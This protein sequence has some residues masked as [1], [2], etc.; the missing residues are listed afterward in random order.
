MI[1][2]IIIANNQQPISPENTGRYI[3]S[4]MIEHSRLGS[5][6]PNITN[7]MICAVVVN[8]SAAAEKLP[9]KKGD[10]VRLCLLNPY[11]TS[12]SHCFAIDNI[13]TTSGI[14]AQI[15][16]SDADVSPRI[17]FI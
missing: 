3:S 7:E 4:A 8:N 15:R 1:Y 10:D 11:D 9:L 17:V 13:E 6:A 5:K 14:Y 2:Y 16:K 12:Y